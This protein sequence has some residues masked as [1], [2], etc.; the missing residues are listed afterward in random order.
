M[1]YCK[2]R[3]TENPGGLYAKANL[4]KAYILN[5]NYEKALSYLTECHQQYPDIDEYQHLSKSYKAYHD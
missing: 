4:G 5:G 1:Q 2:D 3:A